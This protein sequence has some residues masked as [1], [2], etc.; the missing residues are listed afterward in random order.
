MITE[1]H[2]EELDVMLK[3]AQENEDLF[4][5]WENDFINDWAGKM[6][7]GNLNLRVSDKQQVVFDRIKTKLEKAGEL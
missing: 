7:E 3:K 4:S 5:E 2:F 6:G 1:D